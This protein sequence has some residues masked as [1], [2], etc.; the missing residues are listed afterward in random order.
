M[1]ARPWRLPRRRDALS[2]W[3]R[4]RLLSLRAL[5]RQALSQH[6]W[7]AGSALADAPVLA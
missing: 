6:R 1:T 4:T 3:L 7:T 5:L 2:Y